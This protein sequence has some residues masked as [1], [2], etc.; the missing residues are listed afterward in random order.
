MGLMVLETASGH[1]A[2]RKWAVLNRELWGYDSWMPWTHM[3]LTAYQ[4]A[5]LSPWQTQVLAERNLHT[6]VRSAYTPTCLHTRWGCPPEQRSALILLMGFPK[7]KPVFSSLTR[8]TQTN[9]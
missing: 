4:F 3:K 6:H 8:F 2:G 7:V 5:R 1:S 9:F